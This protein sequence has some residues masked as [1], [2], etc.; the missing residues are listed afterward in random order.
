MVKISNILNVEELTSEVDAVIFDLDD[1]L[2]SEKEYVR[3]GYRTIADSFPEIPNMTEKLW[4]AFE[5]GGK[6]IDEVLEAECIANEET[7]K[8]CLNLY[9]YQKPNISLY[10][11]VTE[12]L[13][14]MRNKGLRLGIITDGRPEGQNAKLDALGLRDCIDEIIITDELGGVEFRKPNKTAFLLMSQRL[15]LPLKRMIYVG[16]N[17]TKDFIAPE[18]LGMGSIY[19]VNSDG[20]YSR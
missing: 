11:G 3:S 18:K 17:P 20:L 14:R 8:R 1:T 16:D 2:Y 15:M 6:A 12:M 19:F 4:K 7:K 9:R 10:Q 13:E 5:R